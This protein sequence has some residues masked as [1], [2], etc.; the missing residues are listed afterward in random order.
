M[1]G[2][3]ERHGLERR[4]HRP[5]RVRLAADL[6]ARL[7]AERVEDL[8]HRDVREPHRECVALVADEPLGVGHHPRSRLVDFPG[9]EL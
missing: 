2:L 5:G 4:G 7:A 6:G 1:E 3:A 8:G 9:G